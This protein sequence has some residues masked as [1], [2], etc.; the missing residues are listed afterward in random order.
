M[1]TV[2]VRSKIN[3]SI[4]KQ[5]RRRG[6]ETKAKAEKV[7]RQLYEKA[8]L[9]VAAI[10][11]QGFTFG[12]IIKRWNQYKIMDKFEPIS[13]TTRLDYL[14]CLKKWTFHLWQKPANSINRAD[15]RSVIKNLEDAGKSKRYQVN[16]KGIF[17]RIFN[18]GIEEGLIKGVAQSPAFGVSVKVKTE[19]VP[20]ILNRDEIRKLLICAKDLQNPWYP[21]WSM[22]ILTGCRN[23]ELFA[24]TWDD[25]DLEQHSIRVS[26]SFNRRLNLTKSTKAGY[27]RNVPINKDL[28]NLLNLLRRESTSSHVLPRLRDWELGNQ[29]KE[30]RK[31]CRGIGITPVRFHDLRACFATQL[32]QNQVAPATVMKICGWKDLDTMGRYIRLAGIDEKGATDSLI[33]LFPDSA[34]LRIISN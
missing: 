28:R 19:R 6:I 25:I 18:W 34:P 9:E 27:W 26:K 15:I 24:L 13:E 4:R 17:N 21:I 2:N 16:I 23:G 12:E 7:E 11:G 3:P 20:T 10:D 31:F 5:K 22:A 1:V 29:A 14:A 33:N 30:L 8:Y 32:L